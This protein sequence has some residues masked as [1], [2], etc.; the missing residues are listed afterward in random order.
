MGAEVKFGIS[1]PVWG[2][3]GVLATLGAVSL[4]RVA[5]LSAGALLLAAVAARLPVRIPAFFVG[6]ALPLLLIAFGNA[7]GPGW[8]CRSGPN[9]SGC[10]QLLDPRPLLLVA[11]AL[12]AIPAALLLASRAHRNR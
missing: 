7:R 6:A 3:A 9:Y 1:L 12:L 5:W 4:G 10:D 8:S 11:L 2:L